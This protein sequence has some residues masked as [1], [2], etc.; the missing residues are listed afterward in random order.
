MNEV[1]EFLKENSVQYFA[2]V[3]LDGKARVRPFQFMI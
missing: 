2:T 1:V 3:G